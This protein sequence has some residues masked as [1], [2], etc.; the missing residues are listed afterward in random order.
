L[1]YLHTRDEKKDEGKKE[2]KEGKWRHAEEK[3]LEEERDDDK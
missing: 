1:G 3:N 2:G